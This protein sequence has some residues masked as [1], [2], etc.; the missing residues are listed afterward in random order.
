MGGAEKESDVDAVLPFG[1][2]RGES[3][4]TVPTTYL[5]WLVRG[6]DRLDP[7]LLSQVKDELERRGERHVSAALVLGELEEEL[8]QAVSEDPLVGHEEAGRLGDHLLTA[9]TTVRERYGIA[10]WSEVQ[11]HIPP[12][13]ACARRRP[14]LGHPEAEPSTN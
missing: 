13:P 14:Q 5:R 6:C 2:H 7:W 12:C 3:I 9:F 10:P 1:K 8:S 11:L 4:R